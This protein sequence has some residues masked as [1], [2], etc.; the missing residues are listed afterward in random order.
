MLKHAAFAVGGVDGRMPGLGSTLPWAL[1]KVS[2][3]P[4]LIMAGQR[5]LNLGLQPDP[6]HLE[7]FQ[8]ELW[9][10]DVGWRQA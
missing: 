3:L 8:A 7:S 5:N 1:G 10:D 6:A 4:Q 9:R 2:C